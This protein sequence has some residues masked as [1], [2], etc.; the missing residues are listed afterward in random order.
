M[1]ATTTTTTTTKIYFITSNI[2]CNRKHTVLPHTLIKAGEEEKRNV[3]K[4]SHL[5][6]LLHNEY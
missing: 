3:T 4:T 6:K 5:Y 2:Y 1:I